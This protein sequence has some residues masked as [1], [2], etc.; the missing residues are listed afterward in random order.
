MSN[1]LHYDPIF[2]FH[3]K[4]PWTFLH[5]IKSNEYI[6]C[7][8]ICSYL[9]IRNYGNVENQPYMVKRLTICGHK[10][11]LEQDIWQTVSKKVPCCSHTYNDT[12]FS[13]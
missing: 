3:K 8:Q 1:F 12:L 5:I 2:L 11:N 7:V 4:I 9:R 6:V 13:V 10:K